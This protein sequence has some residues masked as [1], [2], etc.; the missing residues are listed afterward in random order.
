MLFI[1]VNH[2]LIFLS[3]ISMIPPILWNVHC[4]FFIFFLPPSILP[5]EF[6]LPPICLIYSLPFFYSLDFHFSLLH[7]SSFF[8]SLSHCV[9]LL[10]QVSE[11]FAEPLW[12]GH[13]GYGPTLLAL[14]FLQE[15]L[16]LLRLPEEGM[17]CVCVC[18]WNGVMTMS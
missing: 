7:S 18:L 12:R 10:Y 3:H 5:T 9:F 1:P 16:Q 14:S 17:R 2:F 6:P 11:M 15:T 4:R 8:L 13:E